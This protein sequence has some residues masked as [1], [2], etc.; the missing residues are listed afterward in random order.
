MY[1]ELISKI[2][3]KPKF[4]LTWYHGEDLYSEGAVEDLL[5]QMIAENEP[6]DYGK[7]ISEHFNWST[8]YHLSHIRKNILNWYEFKKDADV[9]EIGCGMGAITSVLCDKCRQVTAV[10]LSKKRATAALLRCRE[11]ENL[12]IIVGNLNDISFDKQFD[13]ITL[14]GVLEYQ[15]SYT[16][17]ENPY[18]DFL[19]NI[20]KLLKPDGKLLIAIEN[21]YGLKYWCGAREDHTGIP[22]DGINQYLFG[23][24]RARTFSRKE[25]EELIRESGFANSFFYYPLPD[26]KLP[27]VIYTDEC[28]PENSKLHDMCCYYAPDNATVVIDEAGVYKDIIDNG[29]FSFFANSFL[30]ECSNGKEADSRIVFARISNER[31]TQYHIATRIW[32]GA[33]KRVDKLPL[34]SDT[35]PHIVQIQKN[36]T[37]LKAR[38]LQV[39]ESA[40]EGNALICEYCEGIT[41]EDYFVRCCREHREAEALEILDR[42][43]EQILRSSEEADWK[44]NILYGMRQSV[45]LDQEKY[46]PILK[47]GYLDLILSNAFYTEKREFRWIDQEW[48]LDNV[49]AKFILYRGL[50]VM[51]VSFPELDGLL[52]IQTLADRYRLTQIWTELQET[53][54]LFAGAVLDTLH[55]NAKRALLGDVQKQMVANTQK[56]LG[57]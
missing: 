29:V 41:A 28:L 34:N 7:T 25:L 22:F 1:Q 56:L 6:E 50:Q 9:L 42:W 24:K 11:R 4:N 8:F 18:R 5:L 23:G 48:I 43:Y 32:G 38:G 20:R 53:E 52:P 21:K 30:V 37:E 40:M 51:Y 57:M 46:G 45:S 27:T 17:T 10:E 35:R 31:R 16:K 55:M 26:Y 13:Y 44:A 39:C 33:E 49:P 3:P 15:G 47:T 19:Q 36:M 12:E 14:I 2:N 54:H